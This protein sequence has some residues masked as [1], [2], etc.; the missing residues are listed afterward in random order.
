LAV[1]TSG[2]LLTSERPRQYLQQVATKHVEPLSYGKFHEI[3]SATPGLVADKLK[4]VLEF[5][6]SVISPE[7]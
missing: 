5:A 3:Y 1:V 6:W 7:R 2:V 4:A